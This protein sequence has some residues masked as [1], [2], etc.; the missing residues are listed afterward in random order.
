MNPLNFALGA[1]KLP[2]LFSTCLDLIEKIDDYKHF[3]T[4]EH[5]E[6][7]EL[8]KERHEALADSETLQTVRQIIDIAQEVLIDQQGKNGRNFDSLTGTGVDP[9]F[10][11]DMVEPSR[12]APGSRRARLMWALKGKA[13]REGQVELFGAWFSIYTILPPSKPSHRTRQFL[14]PTW[15]SE[16]RPTIK[17]LEAEAEAEARRELHS[18]L[19]AVQRRLCDTCSWILE[20]PIFEE[21]LNLH[22]GQAKS[23]LLWINGPAVEHLL[24]T[25][26]TPSC[27]DLYEAVRHWIS[28]AMLRND[29]IFDHIRAEREKQLEPKIAHLIPGCIFIIDGLD[30]CIWLK[31]GI[32]AADDSIASFLE[33]LDH[34]V[35][36]STTRIIINMESMQ[37]LVHKVIQDDVNNDTLQYSRTFKNDISLKMAE[38]CAGQFLWLKL[39][40]DSLRGGKNSKQLQAVI[41]KT[42]SGLEKLPDDDRNRAYTLLRLVTFA[43]RPLTVTELAEASIINIDSDEYPLDDLPDSIDDEYINS[44]IL[45]IYGSLLSIHQHSTDFGSST[46]R[47]THFSIKQYYLY[48]DPNSGGILV[49][50]ESLRYSNEKKENTTVAQICLR[51]IQYEETWRTEGTPD[52]NQI[53]GS[54]RYYA[55]DFWYRHFLEETY[56]SIEKSRMKISVEVGNDES[57]RRKQEYLAHFTPP[58]QVFYASKLNLTKLT[59]RLVEKHQDR[60]DDMS[61]FGETALSAACVNGNETISRQLIASGANPNLTTWSGSPLH[62]ATIFGHLNLVQLLLEHGAEA[63][64]IDSRKATPLHLAA[65]SSRIEIAK[66]LL[67]YGADTT[68]QDINSHYPLHHAITGNDITMV[69]L[70]ATKNPEQFKVYSRSITTLMT[71]SFKTVELM[72]L[73]L[74][75][76]TDINLVDISGETILTAA[77]MVRH[78]EMVRF[79][80]DNGADLEKRNIRGQ[81]AVILA[82]IQNPEALRILIKKGANLAAVDND[83]LSALHFAAYWGSVDS[84]RILLK[85]GANREL[86]NKTGSTPLLLLEDGETPLSAAIRGGHVKV[87][88]LLLQNGSDP[89]V[90]LKSGLT[91]TIIA[92]SSEQ[93]QILDILLSYGA[94]ISISSQDGF[95][96]LMA[97][98]MNLQMDTIRYLLE[99]GADITATDISSR[100]ALYYVITKGGSATIRLLLKSGADVSAATTFYGHLDAFRI[101]LKMGSDIQATNLSGNTALYYATMNG[102]VEAIHLLVEKGADLTALDQFENSILHVASLFGQSGVIM[103]QLQNGALSSIDRTELDGRTPLFYAAMR[104]QSEA[105]GLLLSHSAD[106]NVRDRNQHVEIALD[107]EDCFGQ[108]VFSWAYR[109]NNV[110]VIGLME[111]AATQRSLGA[112]NYNFDPKASWC[113][114]CTRCIQSEVSNFECKECKGFAICS[115]C[116]AFGIKCRDKSH[117]WVSQ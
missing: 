21:W 26:E 1:I 28:T 14:Q 114:V 97:A 45:G 72:Q 48:H 8:S 106:V 23:K 56:D 12:T 55:A 74:E 73:R 4:D 40:E 75:C 34:S 103:D 49:Q 36:E 17:R 88:G 19:E 80:I 105:V 31:R 22:E 101:L 54:F 29:T 110:K 10:A 84:A 35:A 68:A 53:Q 86:V 108:T 20:R 93:I 99:K 96:P 116:A 32:T 42:P 46:V 91:P 94:N 38:R 58:S 9:L 43:A 98:S 37:V 95:T 2:S 16:M 104:G 47:L 25:L 13:R 90:V 33:K 111:P 24:T 51:Y 11:G 27:N 102:H 60:L 77:V 70:L 92:S 64:A 81:T 79:L 30:E 67:Q 44:E 18:W 57:E 41:N 109:S 66:L 107:Y 89:T 113:D 61:Y 83:G 3:K 50:N 85:N 78:N 69:R 59:L 100:S 115:E 65:W 112:H 82:A 71:L 6:A 62:F 7:V 15:V 63:N 117:E 5:R 52:S 76:G 39:Q 87:V